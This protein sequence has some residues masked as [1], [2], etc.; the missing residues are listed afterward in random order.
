MPGNYHNG[1][2]WPFI[3]GLYVAAL[4]AVEKFD[5]A[6]QKLTELTRLVKL[7]KNP[8]LE[9]GFNEW[10]KAQTGEVMGV[11]WQT[12]SAALYLYAAVCVETRTTPFFEEMRVGAD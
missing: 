8:E 4:V 6:E 3:C 5:L 9:F 7:S 2:V 12:W 1:G 11:D 10:I